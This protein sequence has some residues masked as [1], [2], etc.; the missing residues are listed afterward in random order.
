[1]KKIIYGNSN[2]RK[3]KINNDYFYIDKT[4]YIEKLESLNEDFLI[5]LRPR[6]FGKSL[7][8]STL[9]YYYDENSAHEFDAMFHDTYIGK[10]PTPL[11][12]SFRILFFEFSGINIDGG[13]DTVYSGFRDNIKMSISRYF[14]D[15]GYE[16]YI[17]ELKDIKSPLGLIKYF[18]EIAKND[19][20][21]LL[22]DEYDQF[23]NAILSYSM[24]DFLSI[25][26]K[27][28]FVRSFYEILKMATYTGII[29]KMF[30]TGVTPITLDSLSSGFNI[31]SNI[32][33]DESFN[34]MAGFTKYEV[35]YSLE[36]SIFEKC[37]D[38]N[39]EELL[40]KLKKWY[41]GYRFNIEANERV[42]N[43]TL[44]NYFISKYD[45]KRCKM[46]IK[47]LDSNVASDYKAIM[48]LFNIGESERNYKILEELIEN[49]SVVG[50]IKD[51][52]DLN[53]EFT[54]DDFITLIY[55]MG[56]ITIKDET[57]GGEFEF[58]IPN[59]V[60]K[61]LYFN[62]FAI[63]LKKRNNLSMDGDIKSLLRDLAL[64][65]HAPFQNQ[66]NEVIKTLS[67]RD[68][69]GFREK[70]F[71]VITLSLLSFADFYFID[72]QP[73][74]DN[75]Y[76]D[77]LLI[78]RDEKV[79]NNYLFE[80]KWLKEKDDYQTVK[81]EGIEQVEGYLALDKVKNIPKL[82]SFLLIG[83]KDGVE[84]LEV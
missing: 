70:H 40:K 77:I 46:P 47:M 7:F 80:L 12:N 3:I 24:K 64:G 21:Y 14:S 66:L 38:I 54:R 44:V 2:F 25:V 76:P 11:K 82:R 60:I 83:S 6:R 63:E 81:K 16:A 73:E 39:R 61:M 23:A 26:G 4:E 29:K 43:A 67:N 56:F 9:Q 51:R 30:I 50:E 42:Y 19:K 72:S 75:K 55:S 18:F 48:K 84:F 17:A 28:G 79:P 13:I 62:Y 74:L 27:G 32:S 41:N 22:I 53:Q 71:H 59:Y 58:E 49:N 10:H 35:A 37:Q 20:I 8:L 34:A 78:G 45:Y 65:N 36:N 15:Y 1:M 68:H 5:F 57:F 69:Y 31:V 33:N 52:Y